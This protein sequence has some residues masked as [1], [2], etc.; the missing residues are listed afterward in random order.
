MT[1]MPTPGTLE[2]TRLNAVGLLVAFG[3]CSACHRA[4][5]A[6]AMRVAS[7]APGARCERTHRVSWA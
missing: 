2:L 1:E 7:L 5:K 4:S 6:P 3:F